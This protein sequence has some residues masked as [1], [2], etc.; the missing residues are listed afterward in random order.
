MSNIV[1]INTLKNQFLQAETLEDWKQF[2][3]TQ[4]ELIVSYQKEIEVLRL[5]NRQLEAML[6][7]KTNLITELSPEENICIQQI[8]RLEKTSLTR[9]LTLEEVKRLDLLV[10]NMK[11]IREES[12]I[13]L[14]SKKSDNLGEADLVAIATRHS[15]QS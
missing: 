9:E 4:N 11:L 8:D 6:I 7:N 15:D 5:K 1:D 13:V 10:K 14:N 3:N 12:T 2:A